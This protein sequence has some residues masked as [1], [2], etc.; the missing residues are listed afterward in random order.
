MAVTR[1]FPADRLAEIISGDDDD[2]IVVPGTDEIVDQRRWTTSFEIVVQEKSSGKYYQVY[3]ERG[4]TEYQETDLF[5]G[6]DPV[7]VVEVEPK[8]V[9]TTK[10][11][12]VK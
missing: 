3:Y 6:D 2:F 9:T 7:T 10:Y 11:L 8:Q 12:P 5:G 1:E 4:S